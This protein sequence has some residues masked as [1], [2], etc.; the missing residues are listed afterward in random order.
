MEH[1]RV[2]MGDIDCG[3]SNRKYVMFQAGK[4]GLTEAAILAGSVLFIIIGRAV[5]N[6]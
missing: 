1:V 2:R 6:A 3:C 4:L 5:R